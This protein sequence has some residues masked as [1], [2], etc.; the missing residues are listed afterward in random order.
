MVATTRVHC[1][2]ARLAGRACALGFSL[3]AA[4]AD[5]SS[6]GAQ[7][8]TEAGDAGESIATAQSTSGNGPLVSI[9]GT[10]PT[11]TDV[12]LFCIR[13][14]DPG[15]FS[16]SALCASMNDNDL[17]LFDP[18]GFGVSHNDGCAASQTR[19]TGAFVPEAGVHYLGI[20]GNNSEA[21]AGSVYP[22]WDPASQS[23]ERAPDG[24]GAFSALGTWGGDNRTAVS[25]YV[26]LLEGCEFCEE[27]VQVD[28]TTW[29]RVRAL[30]R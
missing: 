4:G 22:L 7:T 23:V 8:W 2:L 19:L 18:A 16:A 25:P 10:L 11:A 24:L 14:L 20:T 15:A 26:I 21:L 12:D 6:A 13:I 3:F 1:R 17:W 27:V 9:S 28:G 29:G 30:Y 5:P